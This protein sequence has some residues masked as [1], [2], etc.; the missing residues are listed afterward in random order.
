MAD[1]SVVILTKNEE[2]NI[3]DCLK[4]LDFCQEIIIVDDY[5][6]DST[7]EIAK[8]YGAKIYLKRLNG[9]F[10]ASRNFG[11]NKAK[12][13]WVL[14]VD[15]DERVTKDLALEIKDKIA[16]SHKLN[17]AGFRIKRDDF[18]WGKKLRFGETAKLS[19][20]RL[21]K[22]DSGVW[23]RK[24]HEYWDVGG[25]VSILENHII[26]YPHQTLAEFIK[27]VDFMSTL[28]A[29]AKKIEGESSNLLKIVLYP[30]LK[31]IRNWVLL[32]GFMDGTEGFLVASLMSLHSF[33]A[34]SKLW[35][36]QNLTVAKKM[37]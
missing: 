19:F 1:I 28:H 5:S 6:T 14:F 17:I 22:K 34:W 35:L 24:V 23:K 15:A 2:K 3:E 8:R 7:L 31:F 9:D 27:D 11:L 21:A 10:S 18:M 12:C 13:E 32:G 25:R 36:S 33:L 30:L 26:H 37:Q 4:G 20:L 16:V 29:D